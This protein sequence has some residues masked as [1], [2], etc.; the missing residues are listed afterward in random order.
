MRR[1]PCTT[2]SPWSLSALLLAAVLLGVAPG[3]ARGGGTP[4]TRPVARPAVR[5]AAEDLRLIVSMQPPAPPKARPG[6]A[7]AKASKPA[8]ASRYRHH[9]GYSRRS[10]PLYLRAR[11]DGEATIR[12]RVGLHMKVL[13]RRGGWSRVET[14]GLIRVRGWVPTSTLGLRVQQSSKLYGRPGGAPIGEVAGGH[15]VHVVHVRRGWAR[16]RLMGYLPLECWM[17]G[18]DLGAATAR[19]SRLNGRY[20]GGS[21]MVVSPGTLHGAAKGSAVGRVVDEGRVYRL[22]VLGRWSEIAVYNYSRI[23]LRAWVP[24]SRLRWGAYPWYGSGYSNYHCQVGRSGN[25]LALAEL[26]VYAARDDAWPT[27]RILPNARFNVAPDRPG[28]VRISSYGCI[29]FVAY[30]QNRPGDWS[31]AFR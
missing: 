2:P 7:G 6:K 9:G 25:R 15:L 21:A 1:S 4:A 27:I 14:A 13:E 30:A 3:L 24:T 18:A 10:T 19:Y 31:P 26:K 22:R 28:W 8:G 11:P 20:P 16:V 12:L 23:K 5:P 17:K 29:S